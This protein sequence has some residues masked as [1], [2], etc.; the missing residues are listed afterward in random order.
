M[1]VIT[2]P[3]TSSTPITGLTQ[4]EVHERIKRGESNAFELR[5]TRTYWQIIRHNVLNTFNVVLFIMLLIVLISQDYATVFF[6]GFSVVTNALTGTLQELNAKRKLQKLARLAAH[7]VKVIREGEPQTISDQEVVKDD[8]IIIRPGDRLVADGQVVESNELEIDESHLTGESEA[9]DKHPDDAL[10]S[11]SF[12]LAGSGLMQA[13]RIGAESTVNRLSSIASAY[14]N[15]STPTQKRV[16]AIVQM[17]LVVLV[18]FGPMLFLAGYRSDLPLLDMVRNTI[19]FSTSLVPQGLI[20]VITVSLTIGAVNISR[21]KTLIQRVNAVESLANVTVLCFDK[22]GTITENKLA[23]SQIEPLDGWKQDAIE[24]AFHTYLNNITNHNSTAVAIAQYLGTPLDPMPANLH[25]IQFNSARKWGAVIEDDRTL[26][27]G[28]PERIFDPDS[29]HYA[30]ANAYAAQG[31][32]VLALAQLE[33]PP[34]PTSPIE[35]AQPMALIT[36]RDRIR[37][38]IQDTIHAFQEQNVQLKVISGDNIETV[39]ATVQQAG[40][41]PT[42]IRVGSQ[43]KSLS[44]DELTLVVRDTE[45]FAR[46]EPTTKQ[47][48]VSALK[49]QGHH[50]AMVGDGVNDVP[51]LKAADLAIVMNDGAQISKDIADIVLMNNAMSTLPKAFYEGR[52]ITHKIYGTTKMF[53]TKNVYNTALFIFVM[54]MALPFPITPIQISWAAFGTINIVGGLIALGLVRVAPIN[55]FRDDVMDYVITAG[56]TGAVAMAIMYVVAFYATN[57]VRVARS[58]MTLFFILY[59][60]MNTW[61]VHGAD[62]TQPRTLVD[63]PNI[64]WTTILLTGAALA[65][66]TLL[67]D[68]FEFTW[69]P[70]E[71]LILTLSLHIL[72]ILI[73]AIGMRNRGLL[74]QL[75]KL[76]RN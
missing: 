71:V 11:G 35:N 23:V 44:D 9:V 29:D 47:R 12:C 10:Y 4:A 2:P 51:A 31:L 60:M 73:T 70:I 25:E 20:L 56:L 64:V 66:A 32:R 13:T 50:V 58:A 65:T 14:K 24:Q 53:L 62:I 36:I 7:T 41:N 46:I 8:I 5:V 48:I 49:Q 76:M 55:N 67:P 59:S 42:E 1:S 38:D 37:D 61:H 54:F 52:E 75:Y 30:H 68:L 3:T 17:T 74:H 16:A 22:T 19:V 40:L 39:R 33:T 27:L 57:D 28:A 21:H 72:A 26:I 69:P 45:V 18:I 63:N 43:L 15:V 34:A 6:A